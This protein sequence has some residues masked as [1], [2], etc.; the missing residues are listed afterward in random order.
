MRVH[1]PIRRRGFTMIDVVLALAIMGLLLSL[2]LP[3]VLNAQ[4]KA[5]SIACQ[6]QLRQWAVGLVAY[7]GVHKQF[8]G[9]G[10]GP[11]GGPF[12]ALLPFVDQRARY[13]SIDE[14]WERT[15]PAFQEFRRRPFPLVHC[16]AETEPQVRTNGATKSSYCA[17]SGS[18]PQTY[19][20]NGL[21]R[22]GGTRTTDMLN[23]LSGPVRIADVSDGLSN[24][25]AFSEW[26]FSVLD[27]TVKPDRLRAV[28]ASPINLSAP[29]QLSQ[30]AEL[31]RSVPP[32]PSE[33]GCRVRR[34]W[35][36]LDR[37]G[38]FR[39]LV[40]PCAAP[41]SSVL[42]SAVWY[43]TQLYHKDRRIVASEWLLCRV[44]GWT[45]GVVLERCGR[46]SLVRI[47]L[48]ETIGCS[49][50]VSIGDMRVSSSLVVFS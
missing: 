36:H 41:Q 47:G 2:F 11:T 28:W 10:K 22:Y 39:R 18:G 5:R 21:F 33:Y 19:G 45:C 23:A 4:E 7:E 3:A 9:R 46:R 17:N 43:W 1:H 25:A 50:R 6:N 34:P 27:G 16:P 12:V 32:N 49:D 24:T 15:S 13:D 31:C 40:Q 26:R 38:A 8:P 20:F 37:R 30:F 14:T 29:D 42:W 48:E 44:C 35:R